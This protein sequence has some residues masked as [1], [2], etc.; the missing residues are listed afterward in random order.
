MKNLQTVIM[1][2]VQVQRF[3]IIYSYVFKLRYLN[4]KNRELQKQ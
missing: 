4:K 1:L 3:C 2:S